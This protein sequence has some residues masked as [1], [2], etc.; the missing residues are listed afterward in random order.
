LLR[1]WSQ[2]LLQAAEAVANDADGDAAEALKRIGTDDA[3]ASIAQRY[4]DLRHALTHDQTLSVTVERER[5]RFSAW[6]EF[7]PRSASDD[8]AQ[9]GTFADCEAWLPYVQRMGFDV[10]Y[11]PPIHPI[12]RTRRKG[13]N[14]TLDP[15]EDD[16]G[17]P[18][19]IGAAEGGHHSILSELGTLDDFRQLVKRAGEHDMEIALDIAFQCAPDH[20][21]VAEHPEWFRKRADGSIQYA[22]NPTRPV[23]PSVQ[24]WRCL[25]HYPE[26]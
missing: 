1:G 6:Y 2:Q 24:A 25:P 5:A 26:S 16:L 20:P 7:F 4:P 18:W 23:G 21:W 13:R 10:L 19:A 22:E 17:S 14:N 9:H 11:F 3:R 15:A 8:A 12:G